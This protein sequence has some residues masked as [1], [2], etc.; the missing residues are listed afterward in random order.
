MKTKKT[1]TEK[2]ETKITETMKEREII[3]HMT[4]D[5]Q[6]QMPDIEQVRQNC[7]NQEANIIST[8][9]IKHKKRPIG[10]VVL[11]AIM[12]F[13]LTSAT[14][15]AAVLSGIVKIGT[16]Y[17]ENDKVGVETAGVYPISENLRKYI[18]NADSWEV[19]KLEEND[20]YQ[21]KYIPGLNLPILSSMDEA[22][23]FYGVPLPQNPM[24]NKYIPSPKVDLE[25]HTNRPDEYLVNST[26]YY[27]K[28]N[29]ET[30][31]A[32][33]FLF[34]IN[35]LGTGEEIVTSCKFICGTNTDMTASF[36]P[37]YIKG[38]AN[39]DAGIISEEDFVKIDNEERND[40]QNYISPVN[41]VEAILY[42]V[43]F[44]ADD[45]YPLYQTIFAIN[46]IAY[47]IS[48]H[49]NDINF[50]YHNNPYD[51]LKAIIDAYIFE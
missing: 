34:A 48:V 25:G 24:L 12:I 28:E 11:I 45:L 16:P 35:K 19:F 10:R 15:F 13:T 18:N 30:E 29:E 21:Y 1:E 23:D 44:N 33:I 31:I 42:T 17:W 22:A 38:D 36:A 39:I 6:A 14:A 37:A 43:Y 26:I 27:D 8:E 49:L 4:G 20:E 40:I 50:E 47:N 41:K 5:I 9:Y 7:L 51:T 46:G 2:T 32:S 3:R